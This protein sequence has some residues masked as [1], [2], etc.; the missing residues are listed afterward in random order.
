MRNCIAHG[1]FAIVG[2]YI[3]G[4]NVHN[5]VKKAIVKLKPKLLLNALEFLSSPN[6]KT[7]LIA[8]AFERIGYSIVQ[9]PEKS[10]VNVDLCIEKEGKRYEIEIKD[11]FKQPWLRPEQLS[12]YFEKLQMPTGNVEHILFIDT[13]RITKDVREIEKEIEGFRIIDI[14]QVK[15]LLEES[16]VDIL[17]P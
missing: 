12:E 14:T 2:D 17:I 11:D 4:F 15:K 5:K 3:I 9:T 6:A 7:E 1:Q 8:Y 16:P 10:Y 13:S